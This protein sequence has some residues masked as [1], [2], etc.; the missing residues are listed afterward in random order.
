M[1]ACAVHAPESDSRWKPRLVRFLPFLAP[2]LAIIFVH[3]G[4]L[5][6]PRMRVAG[7]LNLWGWLE[8]TQHWYWH[9]AHDIF[10]G[11]NP[12]VNN[13]K[14]FPDGD[15][16][17]LLYGNFG[18]ALLSVPFQWLFDFPLSYN[19]TALL[20]TSLNAFGFYRL[21][22]VF[23]SNRAVASLA[24]CLVV[25]HPH[26]I[27]QL[28][29]GR[30]TQYLLGW[31]FLA[32]AEAGTIMQDHTRGIFRLT[33]YWVLSFICFWFYGFF[34]FLFL[35]GWV[36]VATRKQGWRPKLPFA[37]ALAWT[38][39]ISIPFGLPLAIE[40]IF[41][42]GILGVSLFTPPIRGIR[43]N[44]AATLED[45]ISLKR[46]E[47]GVVFLPVTL[48]LAS[49]GGILLG[50]GRRAVRPALDVPALM[51]CAA[52][53]AVLALG[54][55]LVTRVHGA[56]EQLFPLPW[57]LLFYGVPF[58]SR[59]SYPVMIFPFLLVALLGLSLR[60]IYDLPNFVPWSGLRR[61]AALIALTP[62]L[63]ELTVS[64][65]VQL[66]SDT[67]S[68]PEP[69]RWLASQEE[70]DALVEYPFGYSDCACVYQPFHGKC[71]MGAEGRFK[72]LWEGSPVATIFARSPALEKMAAV[73]GGDAPGHIPIE[74]LEQ[75][76]REGF[77][78]L[79]F[80]PIDCGRQ[81]QIPPAR[82]KMMRGWIE[83]LLGPPVREADGVALFAMPGEGP[84]K[85]YCG[86]PIT[87]L[88]RE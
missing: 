22:R 43:W 48:L 41:G 23:T 28:E 76:Y 47:F 85:A 77:D 52:M 39:A 67:F 61:W 66:T 65:P 68:L 63:L 86:Q 18:D 73:Q 31:S 16:H 27:T 55:F 87:R 82:L 69:Y 35:L 59:L 40:A 12:F 37:K 62:I 84:Q 26:F 7:D 17:V 30:L 20:F 3:W 13:I 24:A 36:L 14:V 45:F 88:P 71:L 56:A 50:W 6:A 42:E 79:A 19:L 10:H 51:V 74:D 34:V 60:A 53:T 78:Y 21:A 57:Y 83:E 29:Q 81:S 75:L 54:P 5:T 70:A 25:I 38:V 8:G 49:V 72:S 4:W 58:F 1:F 11:V 80:R 9:I 2:C 64:A 46:D 33:C 44:T 32:L 15:N